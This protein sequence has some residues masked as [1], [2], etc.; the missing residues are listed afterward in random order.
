MKTRARWS[1]MVAVALL[2]LRAP[3]AAQDLAAERRA[4]RARFVGEVEELAR[5]AQGHR[6][7]LQRDRMYA[8]L[9]A[10]Q[11]DHAEARRFL[12]YRRTKNGWE[13]KEYSEPEDRGA[14]SLADYGARRAALEAEWRTALDELAERYPAEGGGNRAWLHDEILILAPDDAQ[15]RDERG[16]VRSE[17][18]WILGETVAGR[19]RRAHLLGLAAELR[20][21]PPICESSSPTASVLPG[22][23]AARVPAARV[24]AADL[25]AEAMHIL[26]LSQ[27]AAALFR[28]VF[29]EA[30]ILPEE[31]TV[32]VLDGPAARREFLARNTDAR[33]RS[34]AAEHDSLWLPQSPTLVLCADSAEARRGHGV[35]Q[36]LRRMLADSYGLGSEAAWVVEGFALRLGELVT[37]EPDFVRNAGLPLDAASWPK[38]ESPWHAAHALLAR[39]PG[40]RI[41]RLL[42]LRAEDLRRDD[43]LLSYALACYLMEARPQRLARLLDELGNGA[44]IED[45]PETA[46]ILER[47]L[48]F[49]L[50]ALDARL[51]RWAAEMGE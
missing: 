10:L 2:A 42:E 19:A 5:W 35:R 11:P 1:V 50:D 32:C 20:A 24:V 37:G 6:L 44:R 4:L 34:L 47:E 38:G 13:R 12:R 18:G 3:V 25:N 16:E 8:A 45:A 43:L 27:G 51:A 26:A 40:P 15:A 39:Q 48:G 46:E 22:W 41:A 14:E 23:R 9:I 17:E 29:G 49:P 33:V 36:L 31:L 30:P 21:V 7:Y 28:D